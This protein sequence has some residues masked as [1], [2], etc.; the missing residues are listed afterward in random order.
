MTLKLDEVIKRLVKM[1]AQS[2]R[3]G[4]HNDAARTAVQR[5]TLILLNKIAE[6]AIKPKRKRSAWSIFMAAYMKQGKTIQDAS[7]EWARCKERGI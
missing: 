3:E 6:K 2:T 5:H 7:K 4:Y 1:E